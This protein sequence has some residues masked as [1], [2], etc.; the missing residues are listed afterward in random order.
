MYKQTLDQK[1]LSECLEKESYLEAIQM[2]RNEIL[3]NF[4]CYPE[5][6][7][8]HADIYSSVLVVAKNDSMPAKVIYDFVNTM[9]QIMISTEQENE[10]V[11]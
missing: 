4:D 6:M 7:R 8:R 11:V 3:D 1:V 2:V 9:R 5:L 10:G